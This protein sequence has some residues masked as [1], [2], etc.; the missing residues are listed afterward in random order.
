MRKDAAG[1]LHF[2]IVLYGPSMSGKTTS[3]RWI[4]NEI[5]GMQKGGLTSIEDPAGR[6]LFFDWLPMAVNENIVFDVYTTAGQ[7]RHLH[8][9]QLVVK[10]ADGVIFVADSDPRQMP[11]NIESMK[12]L[13]DTLGDRLGTEI[14]LVI[15]LNKRDSDGAI[16]RDQMLKELGLD[17]G[18]IG[19]HVYET[20]ATRGL[21]VKRA[22]QCVAR[23]IVLKKLYGL[24]TRST[25]QS[26]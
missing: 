26:G 22:F 3:L 8:Q 17:G 9:R 14:P 20:I 18:Q 7:I 11:D 6:T 19:L 10:G 4:Y 12:E 23:E 1:V 25:E 24:K 13:V 21:G 15:T 16:P 5:N 2:K